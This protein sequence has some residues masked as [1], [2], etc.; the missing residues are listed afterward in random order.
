[1]SNAPSLFEIEPFRA[2]AL[3][4]EDEMGRRRRSAS[5]SVSLT[6]TRKPWLARPRPYRPRRGGGYISR[7]LRA[8]WRF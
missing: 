4:G 8:G 7:W 5:S 1:M 2:E 6:R 3:E